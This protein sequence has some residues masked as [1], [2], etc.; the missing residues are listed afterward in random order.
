M[1]DLPAPTV[2]T[3][4]V[5][6]AQIIA[7]TDF[8]RSIQQSPG[9]QTEFLSLMTYALVV[10]AISTSRTLTEVQNEVAKSYATIKATLEE[11]R[12]GTNP[13]KGMN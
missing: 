5:H 6:G 7:I 11:S 9:D 4:D 2:A 3:N 13:Q 12:R 1:T 8:A 10:A